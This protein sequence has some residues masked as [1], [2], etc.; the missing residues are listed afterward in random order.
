MDFEIVE[1]ER[2]PIERRLFVRVESD[3]VEEIWDEEVLNL[4]EEAM[5]P[6]FRAG[7]APLYLVENYVGKEDIWRRVREAIAGRVVRVLLAHASPPPLAP[8]SVDFREEPKGD[9]EETE[10]GAWEP[11][12]AL[13]FTVSYLLPPPTPEEI[14]RDLIRGSAWEEPDEVDPWVEAPGTPSTIPPD[15]RSVIPGSGILSDD[16]PGSRRAPDRDSWEWDDPETD[17]E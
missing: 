16:S 8:P 4:A 17:V 15:P 12:Q 14:E 11:G 13:E 2:T 3:S 10:G 7:R 1:E 5:I 9:G 6:G